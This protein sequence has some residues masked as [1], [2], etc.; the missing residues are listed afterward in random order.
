MSMDVCPQC[1]GP[2]PES[3]RRAIALGTT[4]PFCAAA[5]G[6]TA[7]PPV[8]AAAK[9]KP[10]LRRTMVG[11]AVAP[12]ALPFD[13]TPAPSSISLAA[14]SSP[15]VRSPPPAP[16]VRAVAAP[17][18]VPPSRG[19]AAP[20]V[21][22]TIAAPAPA[23]TPSVRPAVSP[24]AGKPNRTL[25]PAQAL[26]L[27]PPTPA[28]VLISPPTLPR[29]AEV[30][31]LVTASD[32][33]PTLAASPRSASAPAKV[34]PLVA[35]PGSEPAHVVPPAP[36]AQDAAALALGDPDP[37]SI[38]DSVTLA[39][40]AEPA[41][42]IPAAMPL[43]TP[44][45]RR[46]MAILG[47]GMGLAI[48]A[49]AVVGVKMLRRPKAV[50]SP[51]PVASEVA[52]A[53]PGI[54]PVAPIAEPTP[55]P[56]PAAKAPT[57]AAPAP[58]AKHGARSVPAPVVEAPVASHREHRSHHHGSHHAKQVAVREPVAKAAPKASAPPPAEHGDPRPHY[59]RGN[60]LLFAGDSKAAIAAYR[61]AI[62]TAPNDPSAYRGLGLAYEQQGDPALAI[63]ALR[64][65]LKLSPSAADHE[66]INR[67]IERLSHKGKK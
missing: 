17:A 35:N 19:G 55:A 26:D 52:K 53:P 39:P 51:A 10:D 30:R 14:P 58:A 27:P 54:E 63:R 67:R 8:A 6:P 56:A 32:S 34:K 23:R 61:D 29:A 40:D 42:V 9:P 64:R 15:P 33:G 7:K 22:R 4:C 12:R 2:L 16:P 59:E 11:A 1:Q 49:V 45:A 28:P 47:V 36:P 66:M 20:A 24:V 38:I 48:V 41:P 18:P 5:L 50:P 43:Y 31:P 65:Y 62:R 60:A 44:P 37:G 57:A 21:A 3:T 13:G 25:T 46:G